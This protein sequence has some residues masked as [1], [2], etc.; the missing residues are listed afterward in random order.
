MKPADGQPAQNGGSTSHYITLFVCGD[1]MTG[2]GIDQ[3]LSRPS[4][5]VLHEPY[6]KSALGY[7]ELAEREN[8][9]ISRLVPPEYIWGDALV[10][11]ERAAP[12]LR[13]IN[14][15]TSITVCDEFWPDK[16][17]NYRMHPANIDCL[18]AAAIDYCS[19][20]NNH[21][22]D[23]GYPGLLETMETLERAGIRYGGAGGTPRQAE[24]AATF[25]IAGKGRVLLLS[26]GLP[27]SGIPYEWRAGRDQPGVNLLETMESTVIRRI[28]TEVAKLKQPG[29]IVVLSLHW[30]G[31][32]GYEI[33][34]KH[35]D[36]AHLL[37]DEAGVDVIYG[38]SS[39][40]VLGIELYRNRP[41]LYGCGDFLNDY[42]G[43]H[44][45]ERFRGD[46]G[47]MYFLTMDPAAGTLVR[48]RMVPTRIKRL[49]VTYA[50]REE[51]A[52]LKEV[53][54]RESRRFGAVIEMDD[55]GSLLLGC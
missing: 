6:M 19:L 16:G 37:I 31:N 42:E 52:W 18:K 28:G 48:L 20:A 47:L 2:R 11:L 5:P 45:Y 27:S 53:L 14:L 36:F 22:L 26:C 4:D 30:G 25:G 12:D 13:I 24:E 44:G 33:P 17:V 43:I 34:V 9:P 3:V 7:V 40:H 8:G 35:R 55:D 23:W 1:V 10:E 54:S 21:V 50:S 32:W 39:H 38:H 51:R 29:D 46:L 49:R 41:I 15:E